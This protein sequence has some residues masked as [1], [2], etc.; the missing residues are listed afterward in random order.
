ML[1]V[2]EQD[3]LS[4][5]LLNFIFTVENKRFRTLKVSV[6]CHCTAVSLI[7]RHVCSYYVFYCTLASI[8]KVSPKLM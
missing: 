8:S 4:C 6:M 1:N 2:W 5:Q 7:I 3:A